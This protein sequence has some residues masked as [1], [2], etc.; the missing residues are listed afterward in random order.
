MMVS[1]SPLKAG[2]QPPMAYPSDHPICKGVDSR[3]HYY[4]FSIQL[5][6]Y[7]D[8]LPAAKERSCLRPPCN[9][10]FHGD[11]KEIPGSISEIVLK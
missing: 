6:T 10:V 5:S 3:V 1:R 11:V 2:V 4:G 9:Y 8:G 7:N